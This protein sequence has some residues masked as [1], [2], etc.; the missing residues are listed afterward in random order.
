MRVRYL[1]VLLTPLRHVNSQDIHI[2]PVHCSTHSQ[3][4]IVVWI[5]HRTSF[6][7]WCHF[8]CLPHLWNLSFFHQGKEAGKVGCKHVH[9]FNAAGTSFSAYLMK[10]A[11]IQSKPGDARTFSLRMNSHTTGYRS[12]AS[13]SSRG[14]I[15]DFPSQVPRRLLEYP[16]LCTLGVC[17]HEGRC[18]SPH[19]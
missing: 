19:Q 17:M 3:H 5:Q 6:M 9:L 8:G 15:V 4:A 12:L 7:Q 13:G 16:C 2:Q 14:W 11:A 10:G 1:I 18:H